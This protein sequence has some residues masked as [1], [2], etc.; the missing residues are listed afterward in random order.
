MQSQQLFL[1]SGFHQLMDEGCGRDRAD[2][3]AFLTRGQFQ[4]E[5]DMGFACSGR[6]KGNDV[7]P[8]FDPFTACQF[9]NHHLVEAGDRFEVE[10][11]EAFDG[12]ELCR[13]D[14]SFAVVQLQLCQS[15]QIT[16]MI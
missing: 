2:G 6:P 10:A 8:A 16:Y 11:I 15:G 12:R 4:P 14:P 13:F 9:Q 7:F 1:I 3:H 5:G